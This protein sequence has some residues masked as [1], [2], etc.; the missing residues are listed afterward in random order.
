MPY[1]H[2]AARVLNTPLLVEPG[3]ARVFLGALASRLGIAQLMDENGAVESQEKLR[4]RADSFETDRPRN[5]PYKI[6]D[7][8][9]LLPVSGSLVH[10]L[11]SVNP[12]SGMTG[13]DGLITRVQG[14]L[15]DPDV[16]GLLLDFDSPGG[17]VSGC[18]DCAR[19][20][21]SYRGIKP[22]GAVSYDMACSAAMALASAADVRYVTST[23]QMGSIGVVMMHVNMEQRLKD[24][25][26]EVTLIH[27]GALKVAGN[28]YQAL[29]E[30]V[31]QRFQSES[32]ALRRDFAQLI[33]D[34]M[35]LDVDAVLATEAAV[36]TG[37]AAIDIGL[38][39]EL[40]NGHDMLAAFRGYINKTKTMGVI[41][42]SKEQTTPAASTEPANT[43]QAATPAIPEPSATDARKAEQDRIQGI[44]QSAEA[45]G[46]EKLAQH[47]AFQTDMTVDQA[48]SALAAAEAA[49]PQATSLLDA[50]MGITDQPRIG[51]S[52]GTETSE[53]SQDAALVAD[54]QKATGRVSRH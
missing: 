50:A 54:Y 37:Q 4:M 7:G 30:E 49:K 34:H 10:K 11:G 13:Y 44:L 22:I 45:E 43:P 40:V 12:Y 48:R 20:L 27:S 47:F 52:M 31:L 6:V 32:D 19:K 26:L 29:P 33:S 5:R 2:T 8:I 17:E 14:A 18:F 3:Y 16:Q 21:A 38:A 15:E 39:D 42:M 23:A 35:G 1:H 46:R 51:A 25:G 9:A 53:P 36:F 41:T 28:P 24:Q